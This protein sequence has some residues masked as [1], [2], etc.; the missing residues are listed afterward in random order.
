L[1]L[2]WVTVT[3]GTGSSEPSMRDSCMCQYLQAF[4]AYGYT[5]PGLFMTGGSILGANAAAQPNDVWWLDMTTVTWTQVV[6]STPVPA[7]RSYTALGAVGTN[8]FVFGGINMNHIVMEDTWQ[9]VLFTNSQGDQ[10][11]LW[12]AVSIVST[13]KPVGRYKAA[14]CGQYGQLFL[15]GGKGAPSGDGQYPT[16]ADFWALEPATSIWLQFTTSVMPAAR[17]DHKMVNTQSTIVMFGGILQT[18]VASNDL[19]IYSMVTATW[20]RQPPIFAGALWPAARSGHCLSVWSY[21]VNPDITNLYSRY[22]NDVV[23]R[24][25][26]FSVNNGINARDSPPY[27]AGLTAAAAAALSVQGGDVRE[28]LVV[29]GGNNAMGSNVLGDIWFYELTLG[30]WTVPPNFAT[31]TAASIYANARRDAVMRANANQLIIHAGRGQ[32]MFM[33]PV[34]MGIQILSTAVATSGARPNSY[35]WSKFPMNV[36]ASNGGLWASWDSPVYSTV[37]TQ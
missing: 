30:L 33:S 3:Y 14:S 22:A 11:V 23:G 29:F 2:G 17:Y 28:V 36:S 32:D 26:S 27:E 4:S 24:F 34:M 35:P 9:G 31:A 37:R 18:G 8:F 19:W 5:Q 21:T 13:T 6:A 1:A 10:D 7:P 25:R 16:L 12:S 20:K 15:H